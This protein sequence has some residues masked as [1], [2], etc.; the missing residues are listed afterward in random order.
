MRRLIAVTL[1]LLTASLALSWPLPG[2][3]PGRALTGRGLPARALP[4]YGAGSPPVTSTPAAQTAAH[5]T[6]L[7][8]VLIALLLMGLLGSSLHNG[9]TLT[10]ILTELGKRDVNYE[11]AQAHVELERYIE[12][13]PT[14][15]GKSG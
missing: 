5:F 14:S 7:I 9:R 13:P 3:L 12:G 1:L 15:K 6:V 10:R 8:S 4:D 2:G 11:I